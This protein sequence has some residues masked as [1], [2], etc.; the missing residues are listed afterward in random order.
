MSAYAGSLYI[1]SAPS[2]AGKSS[3]IRSLLSDDRDIRLSV[4]HTTRAPRPGE[5]DGEHYHFIDVA[6]FTAMKDQG[7][8]L[9]HAHVHGNWYGTS[10]SWI[11]QQMAA[12]QDVLLEIDWQG[13]RQVMN[14]LPD[15]VSVFILPPSFTE[16]E[17]RLRGRGT[18]P[19]DVITRRLA[20][21]GN[22]LAQ[23]PQYDFVIINDDFQTALQALKSVI[24]SA[25][26]RFA[27]QRARHT[28]Q[29]VEF[30]I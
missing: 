25:R 6:T 12:D 14:M 1:V 13:A 29:F 24:S 19:E 20:A 22:E 21:A 26:C 10:R 15:A 8:F 4:S 7:D 27:Q 3:L 23:A 11:E 16:L 5:I 9:E 18:D 2:G 28:R 17:R 30:G